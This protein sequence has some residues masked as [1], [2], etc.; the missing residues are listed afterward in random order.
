MERDKELDS[1][2]TQQCIEIFKF[3]EE[4]SSDT[5]INFNKLLQ[6]SRS[7]DLGKCLNMAADEITNFTW[8]RKSTL[9]KMDTK[10][11]EDLSDDILSIIHKWI[12]QLDKIISAVEN[13]FGNKPYVLL[14]RSLD[15][16]NIEPTK[17]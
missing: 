13:G 9:N 1:Y 7:N 15:F 4:K 2:V 12:V 3:L 17:Q 14:T 6:R 11:G 10:L 8:M 5:Q 16:T